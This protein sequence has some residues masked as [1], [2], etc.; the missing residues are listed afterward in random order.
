MRY[1]LVYGGIAGIII[2]AVSTAFVS[3]GL[4]GHSSSPVMGFLAMLVG[5]T[6]IFVGVKRYR[7]VE[8]GGVIKFTKA[9]GVG[10]AI[11]LVAA[12][13]YA[14][15]FE[16][17]SAASGF[18]FIAHFSDI[19]MREM[20]AAGAPDAAIQAE[21]AAL[22]EFGETYRNPLIRIP[23]HF[24]EIG[25]VCIIVTLVSAAILKNPRVLPARAS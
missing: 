23:I 2:I 18:D 14:A 10:L 25:P 11:S 5:L 4:L 20:Q 6:M 15:A 21:L 17:Y 8:Q 7:D 12:I 1:A 13:I 19:K 3:A 24:L 9:L 22:Q 16:I